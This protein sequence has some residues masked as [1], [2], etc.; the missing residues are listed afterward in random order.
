MSQ[1][2]NKRMKQLSTLFLLF[3][4]WNPF[5]PFCYAQDISDLRPQPGAC[6]LESGKAIGI[7]SNERFAMH[8][9]MKFPQALY[10]AHYLKEHSLSLHDS[11]LVRREHLLQETWS[12]M[13]KMFDRERWFSYAELLRL[14]LQHS[15]NNAC[16]LL[17]SEVGSPREV[18]S[19]LHQLGFTDIH[20]RCTER[21]MAALPARSA[22]NCC[23]PLAMARLF[24]W[25][26]ARKEGEEYLWFIWDT[27]AACQTGAERLPAIV[28]P[29]ALIVHKTGTGFPH[30]D[31]TQDRN[32]AGL[33][34]LPDGHHFSI[35]VFA[36]RSGSEA[37]IAQTA[38]ALRSGCPKVE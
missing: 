28:P 11:L 17:F 20:I 14:S 6:L 16:D 4:L 33:V 9:V 24:E 10:V 36:P 15:D 29:G 21:E 27:M 22:D 13:L 25:L 23:T 19:Y 30:S 5:L 18:E 34:L 32:D 1:P 7:R 37:Q 26:Y 31:G 8:S 35:A 12:P 38:A 2:N 3:V